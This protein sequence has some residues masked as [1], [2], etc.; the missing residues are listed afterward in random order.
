MDGAGAAPPNTKPLD[1]A[2]IGAPKTG[3]V[4]VET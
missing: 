1:G 2:E 3:A 4:D